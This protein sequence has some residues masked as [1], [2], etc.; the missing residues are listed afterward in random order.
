MNYHFWKT[1]GYNEILKEKKLKINIG[2]TI[3][4]LNKLKN[5]ALTTLEVVYNSWSD[6]FRN[7]YI[8]KG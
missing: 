8:F 4:T 1:F 6:E 2:T 5:D 3:N 7:K